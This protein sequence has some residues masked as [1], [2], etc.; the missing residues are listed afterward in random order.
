M[1]QSTAGSWSRPVQI[2][3]TDGQIFLNT[4]VAD[5]LGR[6]HV[7]FAEHPKEDVPGVLNYLMWDNNAGWSQP[8]DVIFDPEAN[9][10]DQPRA[11]IDSEQTV[12]LIWGGGNRSLR[13]A[14]APLAEAGSARAWSTPET[15]VQ[16]LPSSHDIIA[17]SDNMLYV[18]Y[19]DVSDPNAVNIISSGDLGRT[20]TQPTIIA[21]LMTGI[22][23]SDVRL[24]RDG[25]NR[26]HVVW[27]EYQLPNGVPVTGAFYSRSL[28]GGLTWEDTQ[29]IAFERHGQIGV[30]TV[31]QDSVHLVWR[32]NVGGDGTFHQI[33]LDGGDTWTATD[34]F[35]DGGGFSGLPSFAVDSIG[36]LHYVIGRVFYTMWNEGR[37]SP[38]LDV[39]T[40]EVRSTATLSDGEQALL[41]ITSGNRV[42]VIFETG[43]ESFWHTSLILD[44]PALPTATARSVNVSG[45]Q[46]TPISIQTPVQE[47][48]PQSTAFPV[49]DKPVSS[50]L[51][52]TGMSLAGV[53]GLSILPVILIICIAAIMT[54]RRR[55]R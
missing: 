5:D 4:L 45:S 41:A 51:P 25:A 11:T 46:K 28:D 43:F 14:Y 1:A 48:M 21:Q 52:S 26:L 42:H 3:H 44:T 27:T 49:S 12:H 33:S 53:L 7:F 15:L 30:G 47:S 50:A 31:G 8:I 2:A 32:S 10:P 20:W 24:A 13:Y 19:S 37:L 38:Y 17:T 34:Q 6:L 54:S 9:T 40:Q 22:V 55:N 16:S 18:V 23:A 36:R 29:Q 39:A 35:E